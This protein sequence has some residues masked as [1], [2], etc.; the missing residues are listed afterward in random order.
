MTNPHDIIIKPVVTENS[1]ME[2]AEKKYTFVVAK[3]ANKIEI[4]KAVEKIFDVKVEKVNTMNMIGKMKRMGKH[5]GRRSNWKK[6]VVTLTDGSKGIE[7]FE[8]M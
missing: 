6:A 8:G 7:F 1:M 4:K 3:K 5:I 2:M